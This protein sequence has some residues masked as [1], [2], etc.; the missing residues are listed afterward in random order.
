MA[1][2][3]AKPKSIPKVSRQQV[4]AWAGIVGPVTFVVI[5]TL[6]GWFSPN[7]NSK[8]MY[9]S[10]LSLEPQGWVQK[11]NF[12]FV[13]ASFLLFSY[14]FAAR[15]QMGKASRAG[16]ILFAI[17]GLSLMG[18]GPFVMDTVA[19]PIPQM[20]LHGQIHSILGALVFSLGPASCFVLCRRFRE[21][22]S[23]TKLHRWTLAAGIIMT[24]AVILMKLAALPVPTGPNVLSAWVGYIQR[25]AIITLMSSVSSV[26]Y[27][28][29]KLIRR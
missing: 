15:F 9:V 29:L 1:H 24:V 16:P 28:M 10:A 13:G 3:K 23:W 25:V 8:L 6:M 18:S 2:Q 26:G 7:Y 17:I 22:Q 20:I 5:F 27:T 19:L 21:D 4:G 11:L 14:G 12:V